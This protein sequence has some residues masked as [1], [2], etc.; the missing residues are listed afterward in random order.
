MDL[1][2]LFAKMVSIRAPEDISLAPQKLV[3][4]ADKSLSDYALR[5]GKGTI[6]HHLSVL[7]WHAEEGSVRL[8]S[9]NGEE[10]CQHLASF[11][12]SQLDFFIIAVSSQQVAILL[13][14]DECYYVANLY[15]DTW[16]IACTFE[17]AVERAFGAMDFGMVLEHPYWVSPHAPQEVWRVTHTLNSVS[18]ANLWACNADPV[19]RSWIEHSDWGIHLKVLDQENESISEVIVFEEEG[20]ITGEASVIVAGKDRVQKNLRLA[21]V[22]RMFGDAFTFLSSEGA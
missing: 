8:E 14:S 16:E 1:N 20:K 2:S 6:C 3:V 9:A 15:Y 5:F 19:L 11:L 4:Y 21:G 7:F 18:L 22:R 17:E 13:G 10:Y 12:P